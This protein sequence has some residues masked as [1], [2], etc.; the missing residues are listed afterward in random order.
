MTAPIARGRSRG[1]RQRRAPEPPRLPR[2]SRRDRPRVAPRSRFRRG[3]RQ[4]SEEGPRR[5]TL[6]GED[7]RRDRRTYEI[8][9]RYSDG[10][11]IT[12]DDPYRFWPTLGDVD[13]YLIGEGRH[14]KLWEVLGAHHRVHERQRGHRVRRVGPV[15]ARDARRR[16][17]QPVGRPRAPDAVDGFVGRVG[18]VRPRGRA[19]CSLQVRGHR[20]RREVAAEGRPDGAAGGDAARYRFDRHGLRARVGRRRVARAPGE[21]RHDQPADVDLRAAPR[22]VAAQARGGRPPAHVPRAGRATAGRT[23]PTSASP[24]SR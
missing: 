1:H 6:R 10:T 16:R 8:V 14:E 17:L 23:S 11:V 15:G 2:P 20:R 13:I 24:T 9:V 19:R 5:G 21:H 18:A 12:V 7:S 22:F 4:Q 3:R